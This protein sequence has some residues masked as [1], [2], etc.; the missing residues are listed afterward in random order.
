MNKKNS[1]LSDHF[2]R[3]KELIPEVY[4]QPASFEEETDLEKMFTL[5]KRTLGIIEA[6]YLQDR[7]MFHDARVQEYGRIV[8]ELGS[9]GFEYKGNPELLEKAANALIMAVKKP[10]VKAGAKK[11]G[12]RERKAI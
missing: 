12:D 4:S 9:L 7:D 10:M 8:D 5:M 3:L 1:I 6:V 2:E 11:Q